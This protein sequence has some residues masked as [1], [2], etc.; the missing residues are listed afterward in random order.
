MADRATA[1]QS[2]LEE[3]LINR[4]AVVNIRGLLPALTRL[5]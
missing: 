4:T 3:H 5:R 2:G 1:T